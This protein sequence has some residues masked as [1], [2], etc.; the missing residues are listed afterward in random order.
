MKWA[1]SHRESAPDISNTLP[2]LN[3]LLLFFAV[4]SVYQIAHGHTIMTRHSL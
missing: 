2:Q 3:D 1:R 4:V